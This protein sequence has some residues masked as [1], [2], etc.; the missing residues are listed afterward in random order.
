MA[1]LLQI[2]SGG[3]APVETTPAG[4]PTQESY[5][6]SVD[7]PRIGNW[8]GSIGQSSDIGLQLRQNSGFAGI[9]KALG[10]PS[11]SGKAPTGDLQS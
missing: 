9:F 5:D 7:D 6:N 4:K 11:Q 3:D 8:D 2:I 10:S 1:N